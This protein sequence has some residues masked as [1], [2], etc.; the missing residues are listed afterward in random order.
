MSWDPAGLKQR[1]RADKGQ[2]NEG[3]WSAWGGHARLTV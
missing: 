3:A 1:V 2:R